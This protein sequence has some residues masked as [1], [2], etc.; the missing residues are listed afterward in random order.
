MNHFG[1]KLHLTEC[2][3]T[4]NFFYSTLNSGDARRSMGWKPLSEQP[5]P[6]ERSLTI[7]EFCEINR[8][9]KGTWNKLRRRRDHP[10]L[11]WISEHRA[12]IRAHHAREWLDS[13]AEQAPG[14]E[15]SANED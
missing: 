15:F 3:N 9:C 4:S 2:A 13:K 11:T 6:A 14:D 1:I 5:L 12:V 7:A 8:I 10:T